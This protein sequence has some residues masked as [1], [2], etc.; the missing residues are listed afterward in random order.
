MKSIDY[1]KNYIPF[2]FPPFLLFSRSLADF[3]VILVGILFLAECFNK[4]NFSWLKSPWI[5]ASALFIF[6]LLIISTLSINVKDSFFYSLAFIRW[7][8]F[9]AALVYW[10]FVNEKSFYRLYYSLILTIFFFLFDIWFQFIF[11]SSGILGLT[12]HNLTPDRLSVPFSNNVIPGR[13]IILFSLWVSLVYLFKKRF[14]MNN[15]K[16]FPVLTILFIGFSSTF[17]TG[18]R[19]S[20]LIFLSEI[21]IIFSFFIVAYPNKLQ[22]VLFLLFIMLFFLLIYQ[23]NTDIF[24]RIFIST[25]D[26]LVNFSS[27]DYAEVFL[28][29]IEKWKN[30]ILLGGGLHQYRDINPIYGYHLWK[31]TKIY[32]A[33]NLPL[34]LLVEI[35]IAGLILFY[36]IIYYILKELFHAYKNGVPSLIF[37]FCLLILYTNFF[38]FHTHFKLSHNWINA[39]S[40]FSI[41]MIIAISKIYEKNIKTKKN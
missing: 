21:L 12:Q 10:I 35:G 19:M 32:H 7:P 8:I 39:L 26:K 13:L 3:L 28:T 14:Y 27:S 36:M 38:P 17:I 18:E 41:G 33:H 29:S 6:Y 11:D 5:R 24:Q 25:I 30:N 31:E 15:K 37:L 40:W 1:F 23:F 20:F 9:S 34:N 2:F 16:Y 4:K 22:T